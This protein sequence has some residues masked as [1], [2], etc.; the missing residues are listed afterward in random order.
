M[1]LEQKTKKFTPK[2]KL[3]SLAK[4]IRHKMN[5]KKERKLI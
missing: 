4:L 3:L 1:S 5:C 2:T